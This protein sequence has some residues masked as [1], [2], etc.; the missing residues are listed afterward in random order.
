MHFE[1]LQQVVFEE[2]KEKDAVNKCSASTSLYN[3]LY[4]TICAISRRI[5]TVVLTGIASILLPCSTTSHKMFNLLISLLNDQVCNLK[6]TDKECL[7][8]TDI[9]IWDEASMIPRMALKIIN[10]TLKDLINSNLLFRG[11]FFILGR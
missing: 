2:G 11:K 7:S 3:S 8:S 6:K 1:E 10:T 9:F 4:H 5:V